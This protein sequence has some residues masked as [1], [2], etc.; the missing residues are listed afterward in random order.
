FYLDKLD[1]TLKSNDNWLN[2]AEAKF[3][4]ESVVRKQQNHKWRWRIAIAVMLGLSGLT[5]WALIN[6]RNAR[7]EGIKNLI[8]TSEVNL[9]ANNQLDAIV[10]AIKAGQ[11]LNNLNYFWLQENNL[12]HQ[13]E[14]SLLQA[15]YSTQEF[16]RFS[17]VSGVTYSADGKYIA[18]WNGLD[19]SVQLRNIEGSKLAVF[20]VNPQTFSKVMFSPDSK[21]LVTWNSEN[22]K[23]MVQVWDMN[24]NRLAVVGK[25]QTGI[26][27]IEFSPDGKHF[28][29]GHVNGTAKIWNTKGQE[30]ATLRG[31]KKHVWRLKFSPDGKFLV[32]GS[33][34]GAARLWDMQGNLVA[35]LGKDEDYRNVSEIEFSPDSKLVA[36]SGSDGKLSIWDINGKELAT[37]D[38]ILYDMKFSPDGK[39]LATFIGNDKF[40][41]WDVKGGN[42]LATIQGS[43]IDFSPDGKRLVTGSIRGTV[44]SWDINGKELDEL[45]GHV[46]GVESV[47]F[48]PYGKTFATGSSDGTVRLWDLE[49]RE[50][51]VLQ[52]HQQGVK[53]VDF[54]ANRNLLVTWGE[55]D[56]TA[57]FWYL[58]GKESIAK[59]EVLAFSN[60]S[61]GREWL[62]NIKGKKL[63][64]LRKRLKKSST[65]KLSPDG[66][67][68]ALRNSDNTVQL[69][70][71]EGQKLGELKVSEPLAPKMKFSLDSKILT[72]WT[73]KRMQLWDV[74]ASNLITTVSRD[75]GIKQR[76][77]NRKLGFGGRQ[78]II[79]SNGTVQL[80]K[81]EGNKM[82]LQQEKK[83]NFKNRESKNIELSPDGKL[84]AI[85]S[86][87]KLFVWNLKGKEL[88]S[89]NQ[90]QGKIDNVEFSSDNKH[91]A[92]QG[93]RRIKI[94]AIKNGKKILDE[95]MPSG[96]KAYHND[97]D[98]GIKFSP[99]G[100]HLANISGDNIWLWDIHSKKA[101]ILRGRRF[102]SKIKF[103]PNGK[104]LAVLSH[105]GIQL[106]N[107]DSGKI[108][109]ISKGSSINFSPDGKWLAVQKSGKKNVYLLP[110]KDIEQM[111]TKSCGWVRPYLNTKSKDH[112]DRHICDNIN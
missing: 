11:Q 51:A 88:V 29:S 26:S 46:Q 37:M 82:V 76:I 84:S 1:D 28:A 25:H 59:D 33:T 19:G 36:T 13:V 42:K 103:Q 8:Q 81:P 7:I 89:L 52:A 35:A 56:S 63:A 45:Q 94:F 99:D 102:A 107:L 60:S 93:E 86:E 74:N 62:W 108:S 101:V 21:F 75:L 34:R 17:E 4:R 9:G 50:L 2:N 41:L 68:I 78:V 53:K 72:T 87:N 39:R 111:I 47:K 67:V 69:L 38:Q 55:E 104:N 98:Y 30:I 58:G 27:K 80:W 57:K 61:Y 110:I 64:P 70:S 24:G 15:M 91:L 105:Y 31:H 83:G 77:A 32:T 22:N 73:T 109:V 43:A 23:R 106:Y 18:S 12:K 20:Q 79:L 85:F 44:W 71:V 92:I 40:R 100:K 54:V 16:L 95:Y 66:K 5:I 10:E 90:Q 48:S 96:R 14:F 112:P 3:V 97:T 65:V 6:L 49:G